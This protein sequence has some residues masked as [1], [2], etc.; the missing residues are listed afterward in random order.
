MI[1]YYRSVLTKKMYQI[2]L[3]Y[4]IRLKYNTN[5]KT[6]YLIEYRCTLEE[7]NQRHYTS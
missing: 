5:A 4:Y 2:K 6:K 3:Y 1:K 7:N